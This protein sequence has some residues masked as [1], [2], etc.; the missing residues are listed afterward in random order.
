MLLLSDSIGPPS[1]AGQGRPRGLG[2][3]PGERVPLSS[4]R[5]SRARFLDPPLSGGAQPP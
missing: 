2:V 1:V 4:I 5:R 3:C